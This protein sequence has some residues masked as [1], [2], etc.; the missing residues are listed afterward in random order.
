MIKKI[1][2]LIDLMLMPL[3]FL[4]SIYLY[5]IRRI[6]LVRMPMSKK[7]FFK[8]GV[9]PIIDHYY[10]PH[11]NPKKLKFSLE[12][13]RHLPGIDFNLEEQLQ[14]IEKFNFN[15]ELIQFPMDK[16]RDLEF[17]YNNVSFGPG[18]AEYL[19]NMIRFLKPK[20]II[21]IG[22]GF[23]TLMASSALNKN[24]LEDANYSFSH[25]CIEP[26][27]M[28]WLNNLEIEII[29]KEVQEIE[30]QFFSGLQGNDILFIDSSHIIRPQGDVL[31]EYL[32][33]LP[34]LNT[35]VYIHIHDIFTP[36]DYPEKWI[37]EYVR[38]WNEQYLVEAFMIFNKNF[39]IIGALNFLQ[40]N[41]FDQ[42]SSKC[43]IL[44]K[45]KDYNPGSFWI[46]K[47]SS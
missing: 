14:Q 13:E 19:Y 2:F 34:S 21:E 38:F 9:F 32:K 15:D 46:K 8:V 26:Y 27:E 39:K 36:G 40:N 30:L 4:T 45:G 12:S 33:I 24:K 5:L 22:S 7:I 11:F 43:P 47:V 1:F 6:N 28:P 37:K 44:A 25:I 17:Y 18:D 31:Y 41:Y 35:N 3:T 29:R 23:S 42:L 10:E 20:K 16:S